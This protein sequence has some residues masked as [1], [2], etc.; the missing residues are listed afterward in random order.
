M[1]QRHQH[2]GFALEAGH[3]FRIARKGFREHFSATSR[4]S[5]VSRPR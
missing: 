4:F 2:F 1:V 5:L 3:A